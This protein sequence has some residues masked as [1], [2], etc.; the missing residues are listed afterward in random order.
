MLVQARL[1]LLLQFILKSVM[2][3]SGKHLDPLIQ[4]HT[5]PVDL[6]LASLGRDAPC[7]LEQHH[8]LANH[9]SRHH[10]VDSS[11]AN[12]VTVSPAWVILEDE[13]GSLSVLEL[14]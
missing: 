9:G 11:V 3:A 13:S 8:V 14:V 4:A 6:N 1:A 7:H 5:S 2:K 10:T 12:H